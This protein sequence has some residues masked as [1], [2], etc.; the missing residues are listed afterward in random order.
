V[1]VDLAERRRKSVIAPHTRIPDEVLTS[2][3][4]KVLGPSAKALYVEMRTRHREGTGKRTGNNGWLSATFDEMK[5]FGWKSKTTLSNALYELQSVGLIICTRHGGV[6]V[7]SKVC[8]LYGFT[9]DAIGR[10]D[11]KA[12]AAQPASF[13]FRKLDTLEKAQSALTSG[14]ASLRLEATT[15]KRGTGAKKKNDGPDSGQVKPLYGPDSGQVSN[16]SSPEYGQVKTPPNRPASGMN[17]W[18]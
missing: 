16:F 7:G 12:I 10:N 4:W 2:F 9:D 11:D 5:R 8:S 18:V 13:A 6:E 14:A 17:K 15:R 3:A 1:G